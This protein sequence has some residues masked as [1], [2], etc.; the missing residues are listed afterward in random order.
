MTKRAHSEWNLKMN[1]APR[2]GTVIL[3]AL[4][5]LIYDDMPVRYATV[6]VDRLGIWHHAY[7]DDIID[8]LKVG[9]VAWANITK[10]EVD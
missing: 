2:D 1:T 10:I 8:F 5:W 9:F 4:E 6:Y 7:S 3:A